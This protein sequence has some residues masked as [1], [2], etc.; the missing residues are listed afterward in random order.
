MENKKYDLEMVTDADLPKM[1]E[2]KVLDSK[3]IDKQVSDECFKKY[4]LEEIYNNRGSLSLEYSN[5]SYD[6]KVTALR[7]LGYRLDVIVELLK[8]DNA[9]MT[10]YVNGHKGKELDIVSREIKVQLDSNDTYDGGFNELMPISG[11]V[12]QTRKL[13]DNAKKM[14]D[15]AVTIANDTIDRA[16]KAKTD[17]DNK[18]L[19]IKINSG[20]NPSNWE[21][22]E[23]IEYNNITEKYNR[24]VQEANIEAF[25]VKNKKDDYEEKKSKYERLKRKFSE[26]ALLEVKSE[27]NINDLRESQLS[28][29]SSMLVEI[30]A[31][32]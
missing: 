23:V 13:L 18:L 8:N 7:E 16:R 24:L 11:Q 28:Q 4:S 14:Y 15:E 5:M 3:C 6:E 32:D 26:D 10:A 12:Q 21:N 20:D 19:E 27:N 1:I 29:I 30:E 22:E 2:E 31:T 9:G 25:N 17:Y